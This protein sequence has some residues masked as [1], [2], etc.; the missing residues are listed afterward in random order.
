MATTV[1]I[2]L[3][4][5]LESEEDRGA[6][7]FLRRLVSIRGLPNANMDHQTLWEMLA[8]AGIPA[9]NTS[10]E[11]EANLIL[12]RRKAVVN[13][14]DPTV[15]EVEL[16]Y[17]SKIDS[18]LNFVF[19]VQTTL[20]SQT[21]ENHRWLINGVPLQILVEHT[22][23]AD[24]P[25]FGGQTQIQTGQV[26]VLVNTVTLTATGLLEV[27]DAHLECDKW[28]N[29]INQ[30][31]W[32]GRLPGFWLCRASSVPHDLSTDPFTHLFTFEF[33]SHPDGW[34]PT[35]V[36]IDERTGQPP[37]E[38]IRGVGTVLVD[39]YTPRDFNELFPSVVL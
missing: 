4:R 10:P 37:A 5:T 13:P 30:R 11:G 28:S 7:K 21:T 38:L 3:I 35:A 18:G 26:S 32:A 24:D 15:G 29:S 20:Q 17:E 6:V 31:T 9:F 33:T 12:T 22:Y 39:H 14:N 19:S 27:D 16:T 36:F 2:D 34:N 1:K 8:D 23:P 25:D